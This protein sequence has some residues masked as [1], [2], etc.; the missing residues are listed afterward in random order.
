FVEGNADNSRLIEKRKLFDLS[1]LTLESLKKLAPGSLGFEYARFLEQHGLKLVFFKDVATDTPE[2]YFHRRVL[3]THDIWHVI[4]G[5]PPDSLGELKL[6]GFMY[7]QMRWPTAPFY[8]GLALIGNMFK[9][10]AL[11]P[12][13]YGAVAEGWALGK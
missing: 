3:E 5:W 12:E 7:A 2:G 10:P 6:Q 8:T 13:I 4:L 9:N 11:V 1:A